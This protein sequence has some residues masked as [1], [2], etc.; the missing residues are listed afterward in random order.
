[1][2]R[3]SRPVTVI[4]GINLDIHV[5]SLS[6]QYRRHTSNPAS[7]RIMAGGVGR[8]IAVNLALLGVPVRL[9]GAVG[10][11]PLGEFV[12]ARTAAAGVDVRMTRVDAATGLYIAL[13]EPDGD[14]DTAV[15]A[16]EALSLLDAEWFAVNSTLVRDSG[17]VVVDANLPK[18]VLELVV[19]TANGEGI[20]VVADPVSVDKAPRVA[21]IRGHLHVVTPNRAEAEVLQRAQT[22]EVEH[23]VETRGADG[24]L[25]TSHGSGESTHVPARPATVVD[26]TGAGDALAAGLVAAL[27]RGRTMDDALVFATEIAALVV[28]SAENTIPARRS[29][30]ARSFLEGD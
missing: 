30:A 12:I 17:I 4:G 15:S 11:D 18:D 14:L 3:N 10:A 23:T 5:E 2:G 19:R 26:V 7:A 27:H 1:M 28:S 9:L 25:W 29:G 8:N 13:L 22:L 16:M 21:G 24:A 6:G 20:P